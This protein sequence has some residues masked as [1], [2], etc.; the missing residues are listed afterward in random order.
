[1]QKWPSSKISDH[2]ALCQLMR[3]PYHYII[4]HL[5]QPELALEQNI[6]EIQLQCLVVQQI[7][8]K[9]TLNGFNMNE[10]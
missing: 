9:I 10:Y 3:G 4:T 8:G 1:M 2:N 5:K 7:G 6:L